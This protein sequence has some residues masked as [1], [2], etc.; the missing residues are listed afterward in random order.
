MLAQSDEE[1]RLECM[2]AA[3][4]TVAVVGKDGTSPTYAVNQYA[5]TLAAL[6]QAGGPVHTGELR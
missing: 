5:R 2:V 6:Q 1:I 4:L 3:I